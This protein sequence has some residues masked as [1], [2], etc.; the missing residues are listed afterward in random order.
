M[1]SDFL[2]LLWRDS[3]EN[4]AKLGL[5]SIV[6]G[7]FQGLVV[8]II[9]GAAEE[10]P[11]QTMNFWF[12]SLFVTCIAGFIYT[13]RFTMT[14]SI[15]IVQDIIIDMRINLADKIRRAGLLPIEQMGETR[16]YT[17]I[18]ENTD[19]IFEATKSM[20]NAGASL[21]MIIFSFGYIY[22]IS[23]AAFFLSMVIIASGIVVYT[24]NQGKSNE[25]L[26]AT[27]E[28]EKE[29]SEYLSHLIRGFKEVKMN[30][31]R[32]EDL[33]ENYLKK[34]SDAARDLRLQSETRFIQN[35][36]FSQIS[37]YILLGSIVF[38]LPQFSFF[39]HAV[40]IDLIAVN[41]FIV[42]PLGVVID[43]LP[44]V[45]KAD[46][47][48]RT[49]NEL[50][51]QLT[52]ADDS[53][54]TV[55]TSLVK[56]KNTFDE[57]VYKGLRFTY[58][59]SNGSQFGVGPM[60]LTIKSGEL[61]FIVGGNGSGKSTLM[62]LMIG[63]YYPGAGSI[64]VDD[65]KIDESNYA[66]FRDLFSIIFTDFY[67]FDRLYGLKDVQEEAVLKFI[68]KMNLSDKTGFQ[69]GRF[70]QTRLSTGQKK[71]LGLIVSY[72]ENK[73]VLAFDEVAA[74]QDPTFREYFYEVVL[75]ELKEMGKTIILISHDDRYFH[76]ADRVLKMDYGRFIDLNKGHRRE[77]VEQHEKDFF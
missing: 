77:R 13:R 70:T 24:I 28:K 69:D 25:E 54:N 5:V 55:E 10:L 9:N 21:I 4:V 20:S 63:L 31:A 48:V 35:Y 18:V 68:A 45:A 6:S 47:A 32:S 60:D 38:V 17:T 71:R 67:L 7:V 62:K 73:P 59:N 11:A 74:D 66:H 76:V 64:R 1:N 22:Y 51:R 42:G 37:F 50:D 44:L 57:I 36:V 33:F 41:L 43:T 15:K 40:I 49:L 65:V 8:V 56:E 53:K 29:F 26:W 19:I 52:E 61:I 30:S 23:P 3:A 46:V 16:L 27:M 75:K 39:D 34:S 72:L 14:R 12:L 58:G 2:Q